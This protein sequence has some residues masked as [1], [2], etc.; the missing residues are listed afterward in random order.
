MKVVLMVLVIIFSVF[1]SSAVSVASSNRELMDEIRAMH[2]IIDEQNARISDLEEKVKERAKIQINLKDCTL[3][4]F[5]THITNNLETH[6]RR[7]DARILEEGYQLIGGLQMGG[8]GTFVVQGSPNANNVAGA[9]DSICDAS[10]SADIEIAKSFDMGDNGGLAFLHLEG[11]QNNTI[12]NDLAVF[13]NVNRDA[14]PTASRVDVTELWYEQC[15]FSDQVMITGGKIDAT[16]YLDQNEYANDETTQFLGHMF[17]NSD[18]IDWPDDN[19]FGARMLIAPKI[20]EFIEAEG[21]YM[22]ENGSWNGVFNDPFVSAQVN[23][24]PAKAFKYDEEMWEGNYRTYLWYNGAPHMRINSTTSTKRYNIGM[25]VSCDQKI[26]DT[27]GIFGRFGWQDPDVNDLEWH[28]SFGGQMTGSCW[29]RHD[30]VLGAAVGQAVPGTK[31]NDL[32]PAH[33]SETHV[34]LYYSYRVNRH[35]TLSPD[36]QWIWDPNGVGKSSLGDNETIFVYGFRG[37]VDF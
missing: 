35:L 31:F 8:G 9:N 33:T 4:D 24:M 20:T 25:G 6:M 28:W 3:E 5:Q 1:G 18:V 29:G 13:S 27:Y 12:E 16:A 19:S 22:N 7:R 26:T 32:A 15:L 17:R 37:Q 11:G 2:M 21:V 36:L 23:F 10:W 34:E 30:D 14:G